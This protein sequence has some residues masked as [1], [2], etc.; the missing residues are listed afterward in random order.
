MFL[1]W[2]TTN[3]KR[4]LARKSLGKRPLG[5]KWRLE[6]NRKMNPGRKL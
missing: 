2:E 5:R 3:E 4:I 6:D 1:E